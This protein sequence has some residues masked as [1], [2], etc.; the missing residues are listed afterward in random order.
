MPIHVSKTLMFNLFDEEVEVWKALEKYAVQKE[1]LVWSRPGIPKISSQRLFREILRLAAEH[2]AADIGPEFAQK[3]ASPLPYP[4]MG[5]RGRVPLTE[6][7]TA[8]TGDRKPAKK[9]PKQPA[10]RTRWDRPW[11]PSPG[12][13]E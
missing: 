12:E 6:Q 9:A 8:K 7:P 13:A 1:L 2:V 10:R 5:A 3:L 11:T 4:Q